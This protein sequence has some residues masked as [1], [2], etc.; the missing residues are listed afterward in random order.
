M[1]LFNDDN[2]LMT[3]RIPGRR[4][5]LA[6]AAAVV[7]LANVF[8]APAA[9]MDAR[10]P[11]AVTRE[12]SFATEIKPILERSCAQCHSGEKPKGKFSVENREAIIKGG[13][14]KDVAIIPGESGSSAL[15][16]FMADLVH[17]MEMPPVGKRKKF[18]ALT[19]AEISLV[20]GWIDQGAKWPDGVKLT[21][22]TDV[23]EKEEK[24][25]GMEAARGKHDAI[26][27]MIRAGDH[28]GIRKALK[29]E[30]TV[31]L[32]DEEGNTPLI[33]AAFY[34]DAAQVAEF[35]KRG[36]DVNA[37]NNV[38]LSALMMA[39]WDLDKTRL[40]I[41]RGANVNAASKM[42]NTPLI[43]ASFAYGASDVVKELI[44]AGA[45]VDAVNGLGG[46]AVTAAAEAGDLKTLRVLLDHGGDPDSKTHI[47]ESGSE[48]SAL[49]IASQMGHIDCVKLLLERG[50]KLNLRT[51][52]GNALNFAAFSDRHEVARLLLDR[53]IDVD[54]AGQRVV[55]FR[56]GDKGLTPLIY[57]CL[58]ERNDP[59]LVKWLIERGANVNTKA[60]SGETPLSVA[61]QRGNTK[62]VSALLAAGAKMDEAAAAEKKVA[63]WNS[64]QAAHADVAVL[65]A[66]VKQGVS[67]IVKSGA[68]MSEATG[69]R[70][71]SCHQTS[72][73]A[74][75]W[76]A[77]RAKGFE[78]PEDVA[79]EQLAAGLKASGMF[80]GMATEMPLPVP[81]IASWYLI[82]LGAAGYQP[83]TLTDKF[84]YTL[85]RYQYGDGRWVTKASRAPTDYS[86]VTSTAA[87]IRALKL[88]APPTM[89]PKIDRNLAK[90]TKWLRG[91]RAQ[92]IEERAMQILG[93]HWAGVSK[94][95]TDK[96]A[97]AL[98]AE[99]R[100][101]GGWAQLATMESDAYATGLALNALK[102]AEAIPGSHVAYQNGAKFLLKNQ[103]ADGSWW[104]KTRVS[105][106]QVAIEDIFSHGQD[107]WISTV[108]TGWA[109]MALMNAEPTKTTPKFTAAK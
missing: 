84:A 52:H 53:G 3:H 81:N 48:A 37:T 69:N 33:Q 39:V 67:S 30:A 98:L 20:R 29:N 97:Q 12:V 62:I 86:D 7:W 6:L 66:A 35:I 21:I 14:S 5:L 34:L 11:K 22:A 104:V 106:V 74:M 54:V 75:A 43:T 25:S 102:Q 23:V 60:S 103:L 8:E 78:Y 49:M 107:Q 10:L 45:K 93:L 27:D 55:S 63:L 56:R 71:A 26:F 16:H 17:E 99:Q 32:R 4:G 28:R 83:D 89:K 101:D 31:N 13:D 36:A 47:V 44:G 92:S 51:E 72:I 73:P 24:A 90:A 59:T 68:K 96:L 105:P 79:K 91:Y 65:R 64:D 19:Q 15:V 38:G 85:A 41:Q 108:A 109:S 50:A 82:G 1:T 46:N 18:P 76:S 87:A 61:R 58:S 77:A 88:Y 94:A 70:C 42:G 100:A 40:L 57:A 9:N 80:A 95:E 2:S